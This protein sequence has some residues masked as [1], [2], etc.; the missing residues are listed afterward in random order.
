MFLGPGGGDSCGEPDDGG[1]CSATTAS[2]V[3]KPREHGEL[4]LRALT[5]TITCE[6]IH[7]M[8]PARHPLI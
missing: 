4:I 3:P 8:I 7:W 1:P 2:S 6:L 5:D